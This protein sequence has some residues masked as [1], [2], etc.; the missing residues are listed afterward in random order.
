MSREI[1][2]LT[3]PL[4]Y[5]PSGENDLFDISEHGLQS[6]YQRESN[7]SE[8]E[9]FS[10]ESTEPIQNVEDWYEKTFNSVKN[11]Q[12]NEYYKIENDILYQRFDKIKNPFENEWKICVSPKNRAE[13]LHEQ[14]DSILA[15]HPGYFKTLHRIQRLYYWPKM[16]KHVYNHVNKC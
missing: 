3:T 10:L 11:E 12:N 9:I 7:T 5:I 15:S 16:A 2:P 6:A 13:V 8:F 4:A 1:D 14:H